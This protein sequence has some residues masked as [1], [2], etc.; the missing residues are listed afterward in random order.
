MDL[1]RMPVWFMGECLCCC[2][3]AVRVSALAF[4]VESPHTAS[5]RPWAVMVTGPSVMIQRYFTSMNFKLLMPGLLLLHH[6]SSLLR[7]SRSYQDCCALVLP[8]VVA[9]GQGG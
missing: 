5:R 1:L 6:C 9:D 7:P 2:Q 3:A 4:M 8:A